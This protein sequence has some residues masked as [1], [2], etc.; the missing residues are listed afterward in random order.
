MKKKLTGLKVRRWKS[1]DISRIVHCQKAAYPDYDDRFMY[2]ERLYRLQFEAFPEGQFLAE[3]EGQVVGYATSL[4]VQVSDDEWY[5]VGELTGAATFSTHDPFGDTLYGADIA[6]RPEFRGLGVAKKLYER[7]KRILR[8]YNLRRMIAYGR[9]PGYQKYA[10]T[11]TAE[12][13]VHEVEEGRLSDPALTVHLKAGYKVARVQLDLVYDHRS[14]HYCTFLEYKNEHYNVS[15]KRI[16]NPV[17]KSVAARVRICAAQ[18][19]VQPLRTWEAFEEKVRFFV[20][21]ADVYNAHFLVFPEYVTTGLFCSLPTGEEFHVS[22]RRLAGYAERYQELLLGL[23]T[24]YS[25]YIVG[26]TTPVERDGRIFNVAFLFTPDGGCYSQEK[27]HVTPGERTDWGVTPGSGI[28]IF[29]TPFGRIAVLVCYDVEFPELCRMLALAGVEL[30]FV[31]FSTSEKSA[32]LRVRYTAQ[33]RAVENFMYVVLAG[34]AGNINFAGSAFLHYSQ[35]A[36]LTPSDIPFPVNGIEGEAEPNIETV[37]IA[38]L[39]LAPLAEQRHT[40]SVRPLYDRRED[41]YRLEGLEHV[42]VVRLD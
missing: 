30:L 17:R 34:N 27:L 41:L 18:L 3:L 8:R 10:G 38:D 4:I 37:V 22:V 6:V 24:K 29:Q 20:E 19:L 21:T 25:L 23:A 35:S 16:A 7:R 12:E 28:K 2:D 26:G 15:K 32:Y 14:M 39:S 11:L 33:A 36:I 13:Y 31:P 5:S 40:A 9:I 42:E 1:D